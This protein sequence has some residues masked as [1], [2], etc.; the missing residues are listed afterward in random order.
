MRLVLHE[1]EEELKEFCKSPTNIVFNELTLTS[2]SGG[3]VVD[4]TWIIASVI[5]R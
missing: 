2:L 1:S 5:T 3:L 4:G